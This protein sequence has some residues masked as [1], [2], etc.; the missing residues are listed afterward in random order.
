MCSDR[1]GNVPNVDGIEVLVLA[2]GF[3]ENLVIQ[4]VQVIGHKDVNVA[5]DFQ[6]IQALFQS[7]GGQVVINCLGLLD[8]KRY[9][10][11]HWGKN[12]LFIQK[13]PRI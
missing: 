7:L 6:H 13:L 12:Q 9:I 3:H 4:V 11:T 10:L 2:I 8:T 5:H 1:I